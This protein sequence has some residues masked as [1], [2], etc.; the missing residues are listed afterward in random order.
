MQVAPGPAGLSASVHSGRGRCSQVAP[1][2]RC[3]YPLNAETMDHCWKAATSLTPSSQAKPGR[4]TIWDSQ[5]AT[6]AFFASTILDV[7]RGSLSLL[8]PYGQEPACSRAPMA[9]QLCLPVILV[10]A[11]CTQ[12]PW[13]CFQGQE[14]QRAGL[15]Q[16][17]LWR[18]SLPDRYLICSRFMNHAFAIQPVPGHEA[19]CDRTYLN[20]NCSAYHDCARVPK[21]QN[22]IKPAAYSKNVHP[23]TLP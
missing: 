4:S 10:G 2:E 21:L 5:V 22:L 19:C 12:I 18:A 7:F 8:V 6:H 1:Q 3:A 20:L 17:N 23:S 11:A 14:V 13:I 16:S 15:M 9:T